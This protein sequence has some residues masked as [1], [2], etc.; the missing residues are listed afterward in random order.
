MKALIIEFLEQNWQQ[1]VNF[2][3]DFGMS[4]EEDVSTAFEDWKDGKG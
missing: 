3:M 1:F 4:S 2:C